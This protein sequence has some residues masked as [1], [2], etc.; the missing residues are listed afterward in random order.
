MRSLEVKPVLKE[1]RMSGVLRRAPRKLESIRWQKKK[2]ASSKRRP[3]PNIHVDIFKGS[4]IGKMFNTHLTS[5]SITN[6]G[7]RILIY[8]GYVFQTI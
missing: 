2:K 4:A 6:S 7:E 5:S 1:G 3:L 8:L